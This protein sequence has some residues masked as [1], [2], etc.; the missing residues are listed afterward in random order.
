M[1]KRTGASIYIYGVKTARYAREVR[2]IMYSFT[3]HYNL[4]RLCNWVLLL[5]FRIIQISLRVHVLP[6]IIDVEL[7]TG[8]CTIVSTDIKN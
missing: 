3:S 4:V 1:T 5:F 6:I 2:T 7:L 8:F